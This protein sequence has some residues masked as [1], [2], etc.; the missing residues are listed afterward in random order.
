MLHAW[1]LK[2]LPPANGYTG[3]NSE[4]NQAIFNAFDNSAT[5]RRSAQHSDHAR[6]TNTSGSTLGRVKR[7]IFSFP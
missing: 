5:V 4:Q 2:S 7:F 3:H 1:K 6:L